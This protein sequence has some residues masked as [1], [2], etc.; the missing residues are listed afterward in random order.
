M[1]ET[2][3]R[4]DDLYTRGL[5][6]VTIPHRELI[7]E[8]RD[9]M[10]S[11]VCEE[12]KLESDEPT[13]FLNEI[14]QIIDIAQ[15]LNPIRLRVM[16]FLNSG[17]RYKRLIY[18][19]CKPIIDEII[20]P[21]VAVQ[22]RI[23]L[24]VQTPRNEDEILPMHSDV[25]GGDSPFEV[26]IWLPLVDVFGSK[27][28]FIF[29]RSYGVSI[30]DA[31]EK[32]GESDLIKLRDRWLRPDHYVDLR[33]GSAL[34]FNPLLLHG[35]AVNSTDETR[36]AINWRVKS[37]F[38]PYGPKDFGDYFEVINMSPQTKLG[39]EYYGQRFRSKR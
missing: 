11:C 7:D 8:L 4:F 15:D 17:E 31:L 30:I 23:N 29:D 10:V 27:S 12:F 6:M 2:A 36:W 37:I 25:E 16:D 34:L 26:T 32:T 18:Q 14:H 24:V 1:E 39:M 38:S 13:R 5:Q 28:M 3:S 21:D 20:G 35:H 9:E 19:A 22:K 33:Y